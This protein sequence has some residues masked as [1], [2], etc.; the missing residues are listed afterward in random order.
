MSNNEISV[1][2]KSILEGK[3]KGGHLKYSGAK[4]TSKGTR[5]LTEQIKYVKERPTQYPVTLNKFFVDFN[6]D[7]NKRIDPD[8]LKTIY[9]GHEKW[10]SDTIQKLAEEG[11]GFR[12]TTGWALDVSVQML[13]LEAKKKLFNEFVDKGLYIILESVNGSKSRYNVPIEIANV[14]HVERKMGMSQQKYSL[15]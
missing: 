14:F 13:H 8:Y 4:I 3:D 11:K 10:L 6:I 15:Q 1:T 2:I 5:S 12:H 7:S 9:E